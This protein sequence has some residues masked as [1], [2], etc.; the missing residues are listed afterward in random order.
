MSAFQTTSRLRGQAGQQVHRVQ[1]IE[2]SR[3]LRAIRHTVQARMQGEGALLPGVAGQR[4][5]NRTF[6]AW[7]CRLSRLAKSTIGGEEKQ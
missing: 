1:T 5:K 7:F 4:A 3:C 6:W 2:S